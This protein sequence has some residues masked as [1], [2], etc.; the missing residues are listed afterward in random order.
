MEA[1]TDNLARE[2]AKLDVSLEALDAKPR[3]PLRDLILVVDIVGGIAATTAVVTF[4]TPLAKLFPEGW[5]QLLEN[6]SIELLGTWLSIRV[7]EYIVR[8]R[9]EHE[10]G[11]TRVLRICR[12]WTGQLTRVRAAPSTHDVE[13]LKRELR[14][15]NYMHDR[16]QALLH[17]SES[18]LFKRIVALVGECVKV[19]E[20]IADLRLRAFAA[21]QTVATIGRT[22]V[23]E[24]AMGK[25]GARSAYFSWIEADELFRRELGRMDATIFNS[26]G[27]QAESKLAKTRASALC[28]PASRVPTD[29]CAKIFNVATAVGA[30]KYELQTKIGTLTDL[31]QAFEE[32]VREE[33]PERWI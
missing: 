21:H 17:T 27:S 32:D 28:G 20:D 10:A 13:T 19:V 6:L 5:L 7:L 23:A 15:L 18:V 25:R 26:L 1:D 31:V 16:F 3:R 14:Y 30:R 22:L 12:F 4:A 29:V 9:E 2:M 11:R 24:C 33:T 8:R